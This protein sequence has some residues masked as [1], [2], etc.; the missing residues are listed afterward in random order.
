MLIGTG[1]PHPITPQGPWVTKV[2]PQ[3]SIRSQ[4]I[5]AQVNVSYL[6]FLSVVLL[7]SWLFSVT[8]P[9]YWTRGW[10]ILRRMDPSD[11]N[12]ELNKTLL[13]MEWVSSGLVAV[14][15]LLSLKLT[16]PRSAL[17]VSKQF[18]AGLAHGLLDGS[19]WCCP[20][21]AFALTQLCCLW[22]WYILCC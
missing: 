17:W 22:S 2:V 1:L 11:I 9:S 4:V 13:F 3:S 8:F 21:Q 15:R 6:A 16:V 10:L 18:E 7:T 12:F 20:P 14:I 19:E 5:A